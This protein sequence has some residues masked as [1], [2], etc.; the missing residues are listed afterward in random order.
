MDWDL[1]GLVL[2]GST[3][4]HRRCALIRWTARLAKVDCAQDSYSALCGMTGA[5][6]RG[7]SLLGVPKLIL[8]IKPCV[9][10]VERGIKAGA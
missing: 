7:G 5:E 1:A 9:K 6:V 8:L 3:S 2:I 4:R 10:S